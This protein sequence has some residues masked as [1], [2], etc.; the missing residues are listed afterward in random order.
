[1]Q[2]H[3][4]GG[5]LAVCLGFFCAFVSYSTTEQTTP[6]LRFVVNEESAL[7][8]TIGNISAY[9][10]P[11]PTITTDSKFF[12]V[13]TTGLVQLARRLDLESL[14]TE[15]FL[16][17]KLEQPCELSFSVVIESGTSREMQPL[18]IRV[19][20]LDINDNV[21]S[22]GPNSENGQVLEVSEM[23]K[24]GSLFSLT[25]AVDRDVS[26]ENQ[27]QRYTLHGVE[28]LRMFELD[29]S[30]P[31]NVRLRLVRSLDYE[32]TTSYTGSLEAC[33]PRS[34][35]RQ[36][37]TIRVTDANDNPPRFVKSTYSVSV[38]ENFT[39]GQMVL[40]LE[41][42]DI[43][44]PPYAQMDF[45]FH[46]TADQDLYN[47]FRLE[48]NT[49]R[50]VLRTRLAA[51][52]RSE[53]KFDVSVVEGS[54]TAIM[55]H[56]SSTSVSNPILGSSN[57]AHVTITVE[58]L[59]DFSPNIKMFSPSEGQ[60]LSVP[61]NSP[62]TRVCVVQVTDSDSGDNG[63]VA[64]RLVQS[65]ASASETTLDSFVLSN[66]GK[67]YTLSTTRS[68]DA[69][70]EPQVAV[71]I[72]CTDFG[73]PQRSSGRD[74]VI[75]IEDI[76]EF[77]PELDKTTYHA[78]VYENAEAGVE[79]VRISARDPDHSA[80]L[81]YELSAQGKQY[82]HVDP[83]TGS[84]LTIGETGTDFD[85]AGLLSSTLDREKTERV[86]F[87]VCVS[88]GPPTSVCG[89]GDNNS[90]PSVRKMKQGSN[91]ESTHAHTVSAT[92]FV[93]VLDQN[94]NRPHFIEKGPFSVAEN[95]PR[96][97]QVSGRLVA[98]DQDDGE[99]G[100]VRY[101]LRQS[102]KSAN[103][104][105]AP[106]LF[107]VDADGR[108]QTM[109][110]LDRETTNA[111]TLELMACDSAPQTPLCTS[112]NATVTVLD[113]NDNKPIWRYP[114]DQDK[115]VNITADLPPGHV[116]ARVHA[117]DQD[118]AENG[119]VVYS[120]I[121]PH[122]R[123][124]F[125]VDN[126]TGDIAVAQ[127]NPAAP[128]EANFQPSANKPSPLLPGIY[129]LRLR[130]SDQGHPQLVAE[131]W[132][133]V[134]V[135]STDTVVS[136]GLNF[137]IIV[138]M[139]GVTG[140]ISICLVIAIIC[141]RRRSF[142]LRA[143]HGSH[144]R[145]RSNGFRPGR[146][147]GDGAEGVHFPLK[148]DYGYPV[149]STGYMMGVSPTP[150]DLDVLKLNYQ[151]NASGPYFGASNGGTE[152]AQLIGWAPSPAMCYPAGQPLT[153]YPDQ[154]LASSPSD[155]LTSNPTATLR[156]PVYVPYS[157][158]TPTSD[159]ELATLRLVEQPN[160]HLGSSHHGGASSTCLSFTSPSPNADQLVPSTA[161][162]NF[163]DSFSEHRMVD[164]NRELD[165]KSS[166]TNH[167]HSGHHSLRAA[168]NPY[169]VTLSTSRHVCTPLV[170]IATSNAGN[171]GQNPARRVAT[172]GLSHCELDVESADS[173]RGPS[174]DDPSQHLGGQNAPPLFH[175]YPAFH[176]T[177]HPRQVHINGYGTLDGNPGSSTHTAMIDG[178]VSGP[179]HLNLKNDASSVGGAEPPEE[180]GST[181]RRRL[182]C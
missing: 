146:D 151:T 86:T 48:R 37:L 1:M 121:D 27:V 11:H 147:S 18:E 162:Q 172:C 26:K 92:V 75:K 154:P 179:I 96:F 87:T 155:P 36:N 165:T 52:R 66:A 72:V 182:K 126:K 77:P 79:V 134:N 8:T 140:L 12:D 128:S 4:R 56:G 109:E 98:I 136:A 148:H 29:D 118:A 85:S 91:T 30:E 175:F 100:R 21:P 149:D 170:S 31:P 3:D 130:A 58:D 113:E 93:T 94:D 49:G 138:V 164:V 74:L 17:C 156:L 78:A 167:S 44:S 82:F 45:R 40:Q 54:S 13:T 50:V 65:A 25:P 61:E 60:Q 99:N 127:S 81:Y 104:A 76:N 95:Q 180:W 116:I 122:R 32:K 14:C 6:V 120:L 59:N 68:F 123:T 107:Q 73:S 176:L 171:Y 38:P 166:G 168:C 158:L 41:A 160:A 19:R 2:P 88:D 145:T 97:T 70:R 119:R 39:V 43:D 103:G 90:K 89:G 20:I 161:M 57:L 80:K 178:T 124:V 157:R 34:C 55:D 174:E 111:Y 28:L 143:S 152:S 23:A 51:H 16:C 135:F 69:E 137:M 114:H 24:V 62:P 142:S 35:M 141:V 144:D 163:N 22:F 117:T 71:T 101:S 102:W 159:Q 46:G 5:L 110:V 131:T 10:L 112:L 105:P 106:D 132:L 153:F 67:L 64:C 177:S 139:V 115:E 63:R 108:I 53:Y 83:L 150:S 47:T 42:E 15:N 84:I 173:G 9:L 129:R 181:E 169:E 33:D 7:R 133:Q 125:Q